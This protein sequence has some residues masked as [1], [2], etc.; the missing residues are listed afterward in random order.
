M[1]LVTGATG[2]VGSVA[3]R[4]LAERGLPVRALA[5]DRA[6]AAGLVEAGAEIAVGDFSD[7]SSLDKAMVGVSVLV[8]VSPAVPAQEL[9]VVESAA[10]AGV[11]TW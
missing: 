7:A 4:V 5:R 3:A 6:K 9:A 11:G 10:R 1:I 2:N 8:L